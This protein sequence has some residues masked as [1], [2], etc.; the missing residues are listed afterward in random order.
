MFTL[1]CSYLRH[2]AFSWVFSLFYRQVFRIS[3]HAGHFGIL[4]VLHTGPRRYLR[5]AFVPTMDKPR[6]SRGRG[7]SA[8]TLFVHSLA[9]SPISYATSVHG[10]LDWRQD[11]YDTLQRIPPCMKLFVFASAVRPLSSSDSL[12]TNLHRFPVQSH[13]IC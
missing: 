7:G 9:L 2:K 1:S 10:R 3:S 13:R 12:V 4:R 8:C 6:I 5:Y 11:G